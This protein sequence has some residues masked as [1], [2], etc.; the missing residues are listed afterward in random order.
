[1]PHRSQFVRPMFV[2]WLVFLLAGVPL[3]VTHCH[4]FEMGTPQTGRVL[5]LHLC[6]CSHDL[7]EAT[8]NED[9]GKSWHI[10]WVCFH[11]AD[12]PAGTLS[13]A[14]L[15][16]IGNVTAIGV[17][18]R[19]DVLR[20]YGLDTC[21]LVWLSHINRAELDIHNLATSY[22]SSSLARQSKSRSCYCADSSRLLL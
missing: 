8:D 16:I 6:D 18:R 11:F 12:E 15:D 10:H 13:S 3:P 7:I 14:H 1:M 19:V 17:E 22:R 21:F 20:C 4:G 9:D 2:A 5:Q